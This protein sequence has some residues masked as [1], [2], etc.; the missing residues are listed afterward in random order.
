MISQM[1]L[2]EIV[3]PRNS[4]DAAVDA[5]QSAGI[6]HVEEVPLSDSDT[7]GLLHRVHLSE[8]DEREKAEYEEL[9]QLLSEAISDIPGAMRAS[10]ECGQEIAKWEKL[11]ASVIVASAKSL[12]AEVR[13]FARRQRNLAEDLSVLSSYE[14]VVTALA[15]LIE[16]RQAPEA[17]ESFGLIFER[18]TESAQ[19]LVEEELRKLTSDQYTFLKASL[20]DDRVAVVVGFHK[21]FA[22][23]VRAFTGKAGITEIRAPR[24]LRDRPFE[25]VVTTIQ[26]ETVALQDEQQA[27]REQAESFYR[28]NVSKL[29]AIQR[30]CW[31]RFAR[32]DVISNFAQT[33]Y[34]FVA[35]GWVPR[36]KLAEFQQSLSDAC[37]EAVVARPVQ[38]RGVG[39]PPVLLDNSS[40]VRPFEPLLGLLPLPRY[41][42]VD[43]SPFLA[44]FFPPIFGLMLGDIGYGVLLAALAVILYRCSGPRKIQKDLSIVLGHCAFFTIVFGFVFGE[45]LG[46]VGHHWGLRPLW[47][48]RLSLGPVDNR[49]A[50]FGYLIISVAVGVAHVTVGLVAGII[51]AHRRREE[52]AA[53]DC[54]AKLAGLFALFFFAIWLKK[55]FLPPVFFSLGVVGLL[56]FLVLMVRQ[57][58]HEPIHGLMMPI[59]FL[60][61]VGNVLSYARIMAV[62]LVSVVLALLASHFGG[63]MGSAALGAIV[64]VMIHALNLALGIIDPTIQGLRLHYVEFF[65]KFYVTG[66]RPYAPFQKIGGQNA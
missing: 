20:K 37:G 28:D 38:S 50:I 10:A 27:L 56:V 9:S 46:A 53:T 39:A 22:A 34:T 3:G 35:K 32:L 36:A 60:S 6:V 23:P 15:P 11:P 31:D 43:P 7:S 47:R 62:G 13:S 41:G 14:E 21:E 42:T 40:R 45:L 44:I 54:M 12:H 55:L 59:E 26:K 51:N 18:G 8:A 57:I 64:F 5:I 16:G 52:S 66:G 4:L 61:T 58:M 25:E 24:H 63:M 1:S 49:A 48:E 19:E 65:S 33:R 2:V 29:M 17:H 30:V